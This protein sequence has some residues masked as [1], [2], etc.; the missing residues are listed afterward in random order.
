MDEIIGTF[1]NVWI[2][3]VKTYKDDW[4][5]H[6]IESKDGGLDSYNQVFFQRLTWK[7]SSYVSFVKNLERIP[8]KI[9]TSLLKV[10]LSLDTELLGTFRNSRK[11]L[12]KLKLRL[13]KETKQISFVPDIELD[14]ASKDDNDPFLIFAE[15]KYWLNMDP[16]NKN[17]QE[18]S[19]K[20]QGEIK[21]L[22]KQCQ[23]LKLA[24]DEKV[25]ENVFLCIISDG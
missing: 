2:K 20:E 13:E 16:E 24:V 15:L 14:V 19:K 25:C 10:S 4:K 3:V 6:I 11:E 23:M 7:R 8:L 18:M 5:E 9:G 12:K 22:R 21:R 1:Q 17:V